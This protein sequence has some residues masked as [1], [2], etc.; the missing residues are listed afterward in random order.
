MRQYALTLEN[1]LLLIVSDMVRF[2]IRANW[3]NSVSETHEFAPDDLAD[4]AIRD[5]IKWSLRASRCGSA[6]SNGCDATDSTSRAT[7]SSSRPPRYLARY[8]DGRDAPRIN[9]DLTAGDL[10]LTKAVR[11][12]RNAGIAFMGDTKGGAFDVP[13]DRAR[14]L[15]PNIPAIEYADD[16]RAVAI[17]EAARRLV[18]LRDRWLNP[19]EWVEWVDEPVS[20]YPKRPVARD[21]AAAVALK[22]RTL[23]RLYNA[24]PQWLADAHANFDAAV[25]SA[26]GWRKNI[27]DD[28]A[29]RELLALNMASGNRVN[30]DDKESLS[31]ASI[32][33]R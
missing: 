11:L 1:P 33:S 22:K 4:A 2:R 31:Q 10:D 24:R 21:E 16:S 14:D 8:L 18:E 23:T 27:S 26:Y 17:A 32:G 15:S 7:R 6:R 29:L 9:A 3:T 28:D 30:F 19:P 5:K 12:T 13:G 25:A 20:G